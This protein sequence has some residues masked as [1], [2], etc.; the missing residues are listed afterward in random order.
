MKNIQSHIKGETF[1]ASF[2]KGD[3]QLIYEQ[4]L[5]SFKEIVTLEQFIDL[6]SSFN[7]DVQHYTLENL[8]LLTNQLRHF[9]WVDNEIE[10]AISVV[11]DKENIIHGIRLFF[12]RSILLNIIEI[13]W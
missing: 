6:S 3:F 10:K 11:F 9:L 8:T 13:L 4:T 5:S 1:G 7:L 2:L 12:S